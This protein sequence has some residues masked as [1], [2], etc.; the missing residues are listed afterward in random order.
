MS[1]EELRNIRIEKLRNLEKDGI[2]AYPAK[3]EFSSLEISKVKKNFK[4]FL[5]KKDISVRGRIIAK[6]EHGGS[7]FLDL[8][9]SSEKLQIFIGRDKVGRES[10][11]LIL[12]NVDIG[13]FFA[14]SGKAFYTK[15]NEPTIEVK[16][17]QI[18]GKSLLPLPEKWHGLQDVEE[19]FRRRYLDLLM[20]KEV[21]NRFIVRAKITSLMRELLDK[22]GFIEVETPTLQPLYGGALAEP[23]LTRH[24]SLDMEMY[25]R[26]APELYLKR[27]LVGGFPKVY[28]LGK[29]FRNEGID[30]THNPEFTTVE[31]YEAYRDAEYLKEFIGQI[32]PSVIKKINKSD[33]FEF[34]GNKIKFPKKIPSIA[35]WD[36]LGRHALIIGADKLSREEMVIRAKQFGLNPEAQDSREKIANEIFSKICRPKLIQPVYVTNHPVEISPLAKSLETDKKLVDRFQLIISGVEMAN[37]FSELNSPEEQRSRFEFQEVLRGQEDKE[38]HPLDKDFLEALEYGMPPA[39]GVGI[40]IDRFTMLLTDTHNIKEVILFPAMKPKE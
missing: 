25:L 24:N 35:F 15:K 11:D 34:A 14:V 9:D 22:S 27:L 2:N 36:V 8:L 13:D 20:N 38:A 37:G 1:L 33:T 28:E 39:A 17:W 40:S 26:V 21:F 6:R 5:R 7:I 16:S 31:L 29:N 12:N 19:R 30:M 23:F 4:K 32:L 10:F 18:L 3:V